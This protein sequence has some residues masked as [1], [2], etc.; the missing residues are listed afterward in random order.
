MRRS[1]D[2][3]VVT[4]TFVS[5]PIEL[6]AQAVWSTVRQISALRLTPASGCDIN[7]SQFPNISTGRLRHEAC[8]EHFS[9]RAYSPA[10][11]LG[12]RPPRK[13]TAYVQ[14]ASGSAVPDAQV[15]A[16]QTD[17]GITREPLAGRMAAMC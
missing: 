4:M 13:S 12:D 11:W 2:A 14:D 5:V 16:T 15:K 17:T 10:L 6:E 7:Y 8:C 9:A 1:S 3:K